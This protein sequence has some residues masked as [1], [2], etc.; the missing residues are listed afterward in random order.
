[1]KG[2]HAP[3]I[4]DLRCGL[5]AAILAKAVRTVLGSEC[6]VV[7]PHILCSSGLSLIFVLTMGAPGGELLRS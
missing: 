2:G 6:I 1:M 5:P 3:A 4:D 7:D